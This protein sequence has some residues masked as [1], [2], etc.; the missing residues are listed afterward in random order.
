MDGGDMKLNHLKMLEAIDELA[1]NDFT[2]DMDLKSMPHSKPYTQK[3]A[4]QMASIIGRVYLISHC[5]HCKSCA[6]KWEVK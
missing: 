6:K 3:E 4:R 5:I 2:A 1:D